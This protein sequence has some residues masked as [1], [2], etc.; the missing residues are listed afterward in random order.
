MIGVSDRTVLRRLGDISAYLSFYHAQASKGT[1]S[2][3]TLNSAPS[4]HTVVSRLGA[5]ISNSMVVWA[6]SAVLLQ[7]SLSLSDS[8][9]LTLT[10]SLSFFL[11]LHT[12]PFSSSTCA[13][14]MPWSFARESSLL[15]TYWSKS[16]LSL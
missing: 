6:F 15:T 11:P 3:Y 13:S 2:P 7:V 5:E 4:D 8:L 9:S 14:F 10:P 1:P 12:T 16:T